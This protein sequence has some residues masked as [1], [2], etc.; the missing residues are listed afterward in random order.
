MVLCVYMCVTKNACVCLHVGTRSLLSTTV[1]PLC[2]FLRQNLSLYPELMNW[3][4]W[5]VSKPYESSCLCLSMAEIIVMYH[6][7]FLHGVW[8][9]ELRTSSLPCM[10]F[11]KWNFSAVFKIGHCLLS[12]AFCVPWLYH[13]GYLFAWL[14]LLFF[15]VGVVRGAEGMQ[16]IPCRMRM[17]RV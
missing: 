1:F 12:L 15:A 6:Q 10:Y 4:N 8:R 13:R 17:Q 9:S 5:L 3:P 16:L 7:G 2:F 11:T 14:L